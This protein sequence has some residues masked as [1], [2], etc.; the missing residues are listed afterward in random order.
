MPR[1]TLFGL[2]AAI[3]PLLLTGPAHA[4]FAMDAGKVEV[5]ATAW[6]ADTQPPA[7]APAVAIVAVT[8]DHGEL[9]HSWPAAELDALPP[10][11]ASFA[12]PTEIA[13]VSGQGGVVASVGP[14]WPKV[15]TAPV[16]DPQGGAEP[17]DAPVFSGEA[18]TYI[19]VLLERDRV[20]DA[21]TLTVRVSY[22]ACDDQ[23][24]YPPQDL[25]VPADLPPLGAGGPP[26]DVPAE[27]LASLLDEANAAAVLIASEGAPA[28]P[29]DPADPA[30]Q[31]DQADQSDPADQAAPPA[32]DTRNKFL[33]FIP[34]P[35]PESA[36]GIIGI[37]L[38]G[39]VGGFVLNLTPCVLPVIPI[40]VMTI[41]QHAG[42]PGRSLVL[43]LWMALGVVAFW[44]GIGVPAAAAG[45]AVGAIFGYWWFTL[46]V[47]LVIAG[48]SVGL[49]GVFSVNLPQSVYKVNPKADTPWGSFVFGVMT[50]VLGLP[51]FGL[52]AGALLAGSAAIPPAVTMAIFASLGVGMALPYLVL[53][54]KPKWVDV[55]P[56]TGPASELVKQ[57]MGLLLLGAGAYFIASGLQALNKDMPWIGGQMHWWAAAVFVAVA[58]LWLLVRTIQITPS[59]G[60]RAAFGALSVVLGGGAL[61]FALDTTREAR[62]AYQERERAMAE[63]AA[64]ADPGAII[65]STWLDYTPGLLERARG[66]GYVVVV[67]FTAD[68][69]IN[70]KALERTVLAVEPVRSRLA[71][72][73]VVMIKADLT[74]GGQPGWELMRELGQKAPPVLAVYGPGI[75]GDTPWM[76]NAYN[77]NVV[78]NAIASAKGQGVAQAD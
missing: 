9:L 57:V 30:G 43:G 45:T 18:T 5:S 31:P 24:C 64:G 22:Q 35:S 75:G 51:C 53:A 39:L 70:C 63:A 29:A 78:M 54:I 77:D 37:A 71:A 66:E 1:R 50:A 34:V 42:S 14:Q 16:P 49:M 10:E 27:A 26:A 8:M 68:W 61:L 47:G 73:D 69:C 21:R 41:S 55:L 19:A 60:R 25:R 56:R 2:L 23:V 67:D 17:M 3:L 4:Q 13:L 12:I 7:D 32:V 28:D 62:L 59:L 58:A 48:M 72:D 36:G 40:K 38:L 33:G 20:Q 6:W 46:A 15:K 65:T 52:V 74:S 44:V 11:L 76:A